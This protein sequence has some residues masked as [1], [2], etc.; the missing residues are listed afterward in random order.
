LQERLLGVSLTGIM[1]NRLMSGQQG[2]DTLEHAL[3]QI[4]DAA[5]KVRGVGHN[6]DACLCIIIIIIMPTI[7]V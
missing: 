6:N 2:M 1:D 4:K 7:I 5:I 3:T